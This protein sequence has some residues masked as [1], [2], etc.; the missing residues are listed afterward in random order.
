MVHRRRHYI[1]GKLAPSVTTILSK[2][3]DPGALMY[4]SWN[5][6]YAVLAE[7]ISSMESERSINKFLSTKPL[8]RANFRNQSMQAAEAGTLAHDLVEEWI[9]GTTVQKEQ[10]KLLTSRKLSV[11][12]N[13]P[14]ETAE[15]A[16]KAFANFRTWSQTVEFRPHETE[17]HLDCDEPPF[18]GTV[19]CVGKVNNEQ[20]VIDWKTSKALYPD[21]L[22][23]IAAYGILW[24]VNNPDEPIK[25]YHLLRFDKSSADFH[26]HYFKELED[27]E[28]LF[29][30]LCDCYD[31]VRKVEARA[32]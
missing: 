7:A 24:N 32:K 27:A 8:E 18:H 2:F 5:V 13:V 25:G 4:W 1:N 31:L 16:L 9:N 10:L 20:C 12:K 21:Y 30:Y 23:Q 6:A 11:R 29:L 15:Q 14:K 19:D 22:C 3:K 28:Q 17:L 26:H